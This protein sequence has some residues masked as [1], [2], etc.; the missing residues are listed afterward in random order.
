MK[1]LAGRIA[2]V[3]GSGRGIGRAIAER[4]AELGADV[5]INYRRDDTAAQEAV[6]EIE[7][8]GQKAKAYAGSVSDCDACEKMIAS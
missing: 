4:L 5:A 1:P 3:T 2:L 7:A 6:A 8:M